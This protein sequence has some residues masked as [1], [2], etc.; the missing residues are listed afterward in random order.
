MA[1]TTRPSDPPDEARVARFDRTERLLHWTTAAMSG[2]STQ[3]GR[4]VRAHHAGTQP[5]SIPR[6]ATGSASALPT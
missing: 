6:I 2:S 3:R 1:V 4:L 5:R